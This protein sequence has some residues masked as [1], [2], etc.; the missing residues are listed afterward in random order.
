MG[1]LASMPEGHVIHREAR[2]QGKRFNR[3]VVSVASPQGRFETGAS[4]LDGQQLDAIEA[5]GKHLFYRF[6]TEDV[7]HVHL[8]LF[9]KFRMS[10]APFPEP[11]PACR[12]LLS[13]E[14]D[15]LHLAGP[16]QCEILD[17]DQMGRVLDKL[18]P[19]PIVNE[20]KG[21]LDFAERLSRRRISIGKALMDQGVIAGVGNVYRSEILFQIGV[22]PFTPAN[23][24]DQSRVEQLWTR[25]VAELKAG[26]RL[27]RIV[28][29]DPGPDVRRR[30][31]PAGERLYAYKRGG[32][33]CRTCDRPIASAE[34]D[35]RKVW[36]C[37]D[38]QS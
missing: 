9:G 6:A 17:P 4:R 15:Q 21:L 11:S 12:V 38:C 34:I 36:W 14:A 3:Q 29:V 27:G 20:P 13:T 19:D 26:E 2:L 25:T 18:G 16:N 1:Q 23:A 10:K 28:T 5:K 31:L 8:G 30:D 32:E 35:G 22:D 24:L 7:M 37:R 33:P